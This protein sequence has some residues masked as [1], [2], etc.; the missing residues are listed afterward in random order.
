M[1]GIVRFVVVLAAAVSAVAASAT[2]I[3]VVDDRGRRVELPAKAPNVTPAQLKN[4]AQ[5]L[6]FLEFAKAH[7]T[8]L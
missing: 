5:L 7:F 4:S 3:S 2:G 1:N 6:L 8:L